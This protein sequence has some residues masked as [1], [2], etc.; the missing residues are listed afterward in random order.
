MSK[1]NN[2]VNEY[3][4]ELNEFLDDNGLEATE[5]NLLNGASDWKEYSYGGSALIYDKDIAE[6]LATPSEIKNRIS[7]RD[8]LLSSMANSR[9]LWLDVQARAL[10]QAC[11]RVIRSSK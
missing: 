7:K 1:W 4:D 5:Q 6:R 10:Y 3:V 9:E 2:G 11:Q 8:G